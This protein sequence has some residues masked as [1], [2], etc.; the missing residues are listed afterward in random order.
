MKVCLSGRQT[1]EYLLKANEI[2]IPYK[3]RKAL[4]DYF[5][6]YPDANIILEIYSSDNIVDWKEI[7]HFN[8]LS[9]GKLII[10]LSD[11]KEINQCKKLGIP[12]YLGYPIASFYDLQA[13][14]ALGVEYVRLD[15]PLFFKLDQIKN[16]DIKIR[17]VPNIAYLAY[18]HRENGV[19]GTWI[20]PEDIS[21]YED[22]ID[23]IEF[24]DADQKKEQALYRIYMEEKA[25]SG[26]LDMIITNLNYS[27]INRLIVPNFGEMRISCGQRCQET[28]DCEFCY[29]ALDL[30]NPT[31]LSEYRDAMNLS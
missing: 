10:C 9:K 27:A 13:V 15:A 3:D 11:T 8:I 30:A 6:N 24:E 26:N 2:K 29:R 14:I 19:C 12:Y 31:L 25:W 20:R 28:Q 18:L 17:A 7:E 23:V 4:S 1:N 16:L 22:Y 21:L 5:I